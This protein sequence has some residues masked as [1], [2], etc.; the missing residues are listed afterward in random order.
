MLYVCA[1]CGEVFYGEELNTVEERHGFNDG[2]YETF[3]TC[4]CC[5]GVDFEE[6]KMCKACEAPHLEENIYGG[7]CAECV[8][9]LV[10]YDRFVEY[11]VGLGNGEFDDFM[12]DE[13]FGVDAP[14]ETSDRLT[15]HLRGVFEAR[16]ASDIICGN[17]E[18]LEACRDWLMED[19]DH[20]VDWLKQRKEVE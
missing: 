7:Y 9:E 4:P 11:M 3:N 10:T 17:G 20:F 12:F 1:E 19:P 6:A 5:G 15:K 16:K 18:F 14:R 8:R 2:R 13:C